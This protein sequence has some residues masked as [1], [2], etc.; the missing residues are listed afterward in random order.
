MSRRRER[1][2]AVGGE[3]HL[4]PVA[5]EQLLDEARVELVVLGDEDAQ[6]HRGA[7]RRRRRRGRGRGRRHERRVGGAAQHLD[8]GLEELD[9][10]HRLREVRLDPEVAQARHV[11][12]LL[13]GGEEDD[14]RGGQLG[15]LADARRQRQPLGV[16]H[17]RVDEHHLDRPPGGDAVPEGVHRRHP[18]AHRDRVHAPAAQPGVEQLTVR[19]V[20]VDD[21]GADAAD[22][23]RRRQ[24]RRLGG[25]GRPAEARAEGEGAAPARLALDGELPVH[26]RDELRRDGEAEAGAPVLARR[27]RVLLLEGAE[28]RRLLLAGDADAGVAHRE[29]H[30]DLAAAAHRRRRELDPDEHLAGGGELDGVADQVDHNLAQ[31]A[32]VADEGVGDGGVDVADELE[33]LPVRARRQRPQRLAERCAQAEVGGIELELAGLDLR[34]VEEVVDDAEQA[35]PA[36]STILRSCRWSSPR[37]VS[38]TSSVRPRM[39]FIGVRISWLTLARNSSLAWLALSAAA[40]AILSSASRRLCSVTSW[41]MPMRWSG[42]PSASRWIETVACPQTMAPDLWM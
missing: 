10:E 6:A 22:E 7:D 35:P 17:A 12:R 42:L 24:A 15:A 41:M 3:L 5:R 8:D 14:A 26:E 40:F 21:E 4:V 11:A 23:A 32:G 39:A 38:R 37:L 34:E 19:W 36:D 29:A 16:G 9:L 1:L 13:A 20:V 18:V 25:L 2:D 28:D 31:P 33:P 27:R 30:A